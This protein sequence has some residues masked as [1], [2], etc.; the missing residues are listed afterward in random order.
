MASNIFARLKARWL[1]RGG[2]QMFSTNIKSLTGFSFPT[3]GLIC[4]PF[5]FKNLKDICGENTSLNKILVMHFIFV[6]IITQTV[7]SQSPQQL[8]QIAR[9]NN[10]EL[11]AMNQEHQAAL[12]K[13]PQVSQLPQP[14]LGVGGF[15]LPVETRLGAQ[16]ARVGATQMFPWPG[17]LRLQKEQVLT[18]AEVFTERI[19]AFQLN[20]R[21]QI[22]SAWLDLYEVRNSQ[23]IIENRLVL[24][25]ALKKLAETK[26]AAGKASLADVLRV[27]LKIKEL[28]QQIKILNAQL[29]KPQ[30]ALNQLLNRPLETLVEV[31]GELDFAELSWEKDSLFQRIDV[32]HPSLRI[33]GIQ[34]EVARKSME[35]NQ[36]AGKPSFG[37]GAD[38]I[39][40]SKVPED[41]VTHAIPENNG[42]DILQ[43]RGTLTIPIYRK[44]YQAR[45]QEEELKI[46]ALE[47]RKEATLDLFWSKIE[48]VY[49]DHEKALL[50][51]ELYRD[52]IKTVQST[53]KILEADYSNQS[54][55]FD[56]LI[57]LEAQ[58]IDYDLELLRAIVMSHK[59]K[60]EVEKY[61]I[62]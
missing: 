8:Y 41:H 32:Y 24:L 61:V 17:T 43:V 35:V 39:T 36:Q 53:I 45:Q 15:I 18:E 31:E 38:Y 58:L 7:L 12:T 22:V 40:V 55:G 44:K 25:R 60:A 48:Q 11:K 37:L 49:A 56:E 1:G 27:D 13:A 9:Q 20:L 26:V 23:Q 16:R 46:E 6:G 51:Y 29:R 5:D 4:K 62:Y 34:Q 33:F 54:R 47:N 42:R 3:F 14:E 50:T 30:I 57:Q 19:A 28:S 52:Q 10:P 21:Y 59:A 2:N